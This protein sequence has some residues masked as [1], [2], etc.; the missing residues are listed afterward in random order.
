MTATTAAT[1]QKSWIVALLLCFFVGV[2]GVHR[3]YTG[4]V[5]TGI[6]MLVTLGG[7]GVWTLI[8]FIMIAVGSFKDKQGLAL[9]R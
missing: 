6:L 7:F 2:L 8:D 4:K 5:G 9:A 1:G 3:F